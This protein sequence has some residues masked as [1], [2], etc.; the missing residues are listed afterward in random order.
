MKVAVYIE[1]GVTQLVLTAESDWE[2][3][4]INSVDK[5]GQTLTVKRG[6]FYECQGGWHRQGGDDDSL[7]LIVSERPTS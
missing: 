7:I 2:K 1:G 3:N 4:A 5:G 6:Q